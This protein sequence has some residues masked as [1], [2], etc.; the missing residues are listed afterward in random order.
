[1]CQLAN[2]SLLFS[3]AVNGF[4]LF[5]HYFLLCW[6][7]W[8]FVQTTPVLSRHKNWKSIF[9]QRGNIVSRECITFEHKKMILEVDSIVG[10]NYCYVHLETTHFRMQLFLCRVHH[11]S[12]KMLLPT[13]TA[14]QAWPSKRNCCNLSLS[15]SLFLDHSIIQSISEKSQIAKI[16]RRDNLSKW[17]YKNC[18]RQK[19][20][21]SDTIDDFFTAKTC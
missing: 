1:M 18:E 10:I 4:Q 21:R 15:L 3:W 14:V 6:F 13:V 17:L 11:K 7:L 16:V 2:I 19:T 20:R 9:G 5:C 12:R 8:F